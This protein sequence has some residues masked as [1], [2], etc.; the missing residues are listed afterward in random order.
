MLL[1]SE[2]GQ[3]LLVIHDPSQIKILQSCRYQSLIF[4]LISLM[5]VIDNLCL[6]IYYFSI[7]NCFIDLIIFWKLITVQICLAKLRLI[8]VSRRNI[9]TYFS[10]AVKITYLIPIQKIQNDFI[11]YLFFLILSFFQRELFTHM[12][13]WTTFMYWPE[14]YPQ[15]PEDCGI[16]KRNVTVEADVEELDS[17][18]VLKRDADVNLNKGKQVQEMIP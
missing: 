16:Q 11:S 5:S 6:Y 8:C 17:P 18:L 4:F 12:N 10:S 15:T 9:C 13:V 3:D 1:N 2:F 14:T 7:Y